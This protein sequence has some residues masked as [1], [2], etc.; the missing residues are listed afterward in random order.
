MATAVNLVAVTSSTALTAAKRLVTMVP[1]VVFVTSHVKSGASIL[2]AVGCAL[3]HALRV[4]SRSVPLVALTVSVACL[5]ELHVI[6]SLAPSAVRAH[7]T[8]ATSVRVFAVP[9]VPVLVSA[10]NVPMR[11]SSLV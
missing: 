11:T 6:G 8:A 3:S 4:Q 1:T 10:K 7:S 2:T 9:L 5:V